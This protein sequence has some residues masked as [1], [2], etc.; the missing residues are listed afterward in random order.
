MSRSIQFLEGET[1][2]NNSY[3]QIDEYESDILRALDHR[4][5]AHLIEAANKLK[6]V[7]DDMILVAGKM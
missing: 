6:V 7:L 5:W 1:A 2:L 3:N 4:E